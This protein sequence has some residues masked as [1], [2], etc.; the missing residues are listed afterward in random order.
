M[1]IEYL[2]ALRKATELAKMKEKRSTS[3]GGSGGGGFRVA[4][5]NRGLVVN[6]PLP[7]SLPPPPPPPQGMGGFPQ[8]GSVGAGGL[9]SA[10]PRARRGPC[11]Q[12]GMMGHFKA[13]CPRAVG[14]AR[15]PGV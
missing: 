10:Y 13:E 9:P 8:W 4:C 2:K 12:C 7:V 1:S 14:P 6:S 15:G 11:H 3:G 5:G